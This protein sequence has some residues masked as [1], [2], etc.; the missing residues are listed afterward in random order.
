[1]TENNLFKDY[2]K[3]WNKYICK[4]EVKYFNIHNKPI[5][6]QDTSRKYVS[7][8]HFIVLSASSFNDQ[9][10]VGHVID[11]VTTYLK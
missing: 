10:D 9:N 6:R 1:M 11:E 8:N 7:H 5:L 2:Q 4:M 3:Y